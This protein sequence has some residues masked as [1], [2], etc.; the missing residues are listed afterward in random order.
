VAFET[1]GGDPRR[2][3]SDHPIRIITLQIPPWDPQ[4]IRI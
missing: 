1:T 4:V 2:P 3:V